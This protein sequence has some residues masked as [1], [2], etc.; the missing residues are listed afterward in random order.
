ME[1]VNQDGTVYAGTRHWLFF[2]GPAGGGIYQIYPINFIFTK[3]NNYIYIATD[4][5]IIS[6]YTFEVNTNVRAELGDYSLKFSSICVD[7]SNTVW[8][9]TEQ[10]G[11]INLNTG[12]RFN[13]TNSSQIGD[14]INT[15]AVSPSGVV[16]IGYNY[17]NVSH[18]SVSYYNGNL[19][20]LQV[21]P[22]NSNTNT[23]FIDKNNIKWIGTTQG[24]VEYNESSGR[25]VY[26]LDKTGLNID[27]VRGVGE[28]SF[29]RVWIA[30]YDKGI[31]V[32]KK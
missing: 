12:E 19:T 14:N 5:T 3:G 26:D 28:D 32:K 23:I 11:L 1:A 31:F 8:L 15:L 30:T 4:T 13:A 20:A 10:N 16:C 29:G 22:P 2:M 27:D 9:G 6:G 25:A 7:N 21:L 24:L 18:S 17:T